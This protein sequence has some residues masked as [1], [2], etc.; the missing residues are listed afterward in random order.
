MVFF[1]H[2]EFITSVSYDS[3]SCVYICEC[4]ELFAYYLY[5]VYFSFSTVAAYIANKVVYNNVIKL[6]AIRNSACDSVKLD[7]VHKQ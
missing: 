7:T 2:N 6:I 3:I 1:V 5:I 4:C